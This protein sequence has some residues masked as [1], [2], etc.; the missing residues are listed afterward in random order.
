MIP[1]EE[2]ILLVQDLDGTVEERA[3]CPI[4]WTLDAAR[5]A[6]GMLDPIAHRAG[7]TLAIY[8]SVLRGRGNDLDLLAV[9][10]RPDT[11]PVDLR[12]RLVEHL[13]LNPTAL[14][15]RYEGLMGTQCFVLQLKNGRVID[16][17]VREK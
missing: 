1:F 6:W 12:D 4:G 3:G 8:G 15:G 11:D 13:A 7:Y 14:E 5:Q 9:P 17:Q 2:P 16:L 10:W